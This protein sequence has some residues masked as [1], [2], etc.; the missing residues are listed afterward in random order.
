MHYVEIPSSVA[1]IGLIYLLFKYCKYGRDIFLGLAYAVFGF[2]V[3]VFISPFCGY[4][5][6]I[7]GIFFVALTLIQMVVDKRK[8]RKGEPTAYQKFCQEM[9]EK[10]EEDYMNRL[11]NWSKHMK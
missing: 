7:M 1:I 8:Q 10:R 6:M 3:K 2:F 11:E 9:D 4:G 5:C